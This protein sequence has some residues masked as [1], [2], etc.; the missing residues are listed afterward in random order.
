MGA[1]RRPLAWALGAAAALLALGATDRGLAR[2]LAERGPAT[3]VVGAAY[4]LSAPPMALLDGVRGHRTRLYAC[5]FLH[6][7]K[8]LPAGTLALPA[9]LLLVPLAPRH[10]PDAWLDSLVEAFQEDSCTRPAWSVLP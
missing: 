7:I 10:L 2:R 4:V 5:R 1:N 8:M 3:P 6:G 9:G